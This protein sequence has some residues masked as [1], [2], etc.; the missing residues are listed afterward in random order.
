MSENLKNEKIENTAEVE[1]NEGSDKCTADTAEA[2]KNSAAAVYGKFA[3]AQALYTAYLALEAE[4]TRRSQR[5]KELE[6]GNKAQTDDA[7]SRT[8]K[9]SAE[10]PSHAGEASISSQPLSEEI[11]RAVIEDYLKGVASGKGAPIL[12]G[13]VGCATPKASPRSIKEAGKLVRQFF[14][15]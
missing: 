2:D 14:N 8:G 1:N 11:R 5:L 9:A 12:T 3:D 6:G 10:E 15:E 7:S 13:G 4:F